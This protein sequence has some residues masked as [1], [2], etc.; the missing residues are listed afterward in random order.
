MEISTS[1]SRIVKR[2]RK[3][4]PPTK[5]VGVTAGC[6][7]MEDAGCTWAWPLE[8]LCLLVGQDG[9]SRPAWKVR[10]G[11]RVVAYGEAGGRSREVAKAE[12]LEPM[13]SRDD[14]LCERLQREWQGASGAQR[15]G[16]LLAMDEMEA[17]LAAPESFVSMVGELR[18]S[19]ATAALKDLGPSGSIGHEFYPNMFRPLVGDSVRVLWDDGIWYEAIM[20]GTAR[21]ERRSAC[22]TTYFSARPTTLRVRYAVDG[23]RDSLEWPEPEAFVMA[24]PVAER[25]PAR[26]RCSPAMPSEMPR[27][28]RPFLAKDRS[29]IFEL[30]SHKVR[31]LFSSR[32][33]Q[34]VRLPRQNSISREPRENAAATEEEDRV[35]Q[36]PKPVLQRSKNET[37][38]QAFEE[39]VLKVEDLE[40]QEE[41]DSEVKELTA[42]CTRCCEALR[43][44]ARPLGA[45]IEDFAANPRSDFVFRLPRGENSDDW[46]F[47]FLTDDPSPV[48]ALFELAHQLTY[49]FNHLLAHGYE[50]DSELCAAAYAHGEGVATLND[51]DDAWASQAR[52]AQFVLLSMADASP[53][54]VDLEALHHV[55]R[56][57]SRVWQEHECLLGPSDVLAAGAPC[58]ATLPRSNV[59]EPHKTWIGGAKAVAKAY[60]RRMQ[61]LAE[62]EDED[63]PCATTAKKQ[64]RPP[65]AAARAAMCGDR[66][67]L[68]MESVQPEIAKSL[69]GGLGT[70]FSRRVEVVRLVDQEQRLLDGEKGVVARL[71]IEKRAAIPYAGVAVTDDEIGQL[72]LRKPRAVARWLMY[73]YEFAPQI[74]VLP[75]LGCPTF[76]PAPFINCARGPNPNEALA[77][78]ATTALSASSED[79]RP[80]RAW[81]S[82]YIGLRIRRLVLNTATVPKGSSRYADGTVVA[83]LD[84]S[85][86]DF[87]DDSGSPASLW[88]VK[89]DASGPLGDEEEDLELHEVLASAKAP[90]LERASSSQS[91]DCPSATRPISS[92][93]ASRS[94]ESNGAA[95]ANCHFT[96]VRGDGGAVIGVYIVTSRRIAAGE[97]LL[98]T[99]GR[100]FWD[101]W[102]QRHARLVDLERCAERFVCEAN[103]LVDIASRLDAAKLIRRPHEAWRQLVGVPFEATRSVRGE[104]RR[105]A[106]VAGLV[107]EASS[108]TALAHTPQPGERVEGYWRGAAPSFPGTVRAASDR[109]CDIAYDDGCVETNVPLKRLARLSPPLHWRRLRKLPVGTWVRKFEPIIANATSLK[110]AKILR[111]EGVVV[112]A[113]DATIDVLGDDGA[114]NLTEN[115]ADWEPLF[116]VRFADDNEQ[117]VMGLD[118][119]RHLA[120]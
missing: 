75:Y 46:P 49:V 96:E 3:K 100:E 106:V 84:A 19:A 52:T 33:E 18:L 113:T 119:L 13:P 60:L 15:D 54:A 72:L 39:A 43:G 40:N 36:S 26:R 55:A 65:G 9:R 73:R 38:R 107:V 98:V 35:K 70:D 21:D 63:P 85:E 23:E 66:R 104:R 83:W 44:L 116:I 105:K 109:A 82:E 110:K 74:S 118:Q 95:K 32:S 61:S 79:A 102:I 87:V 111:R 7:Q 50:L 57:S 5:K 48:E 28:W 45:L 115:L 58:F 92:S 89:Y 97:S 81:G 78:S 101:G 114:L 77:W 64:Y 30:P 1:S 20:E 25:R 71:D 27:D 53:G 6:R 17:R 11:K 67:E 24:P 86:S 90:P 80:W 62:D 37:G 59:A 51:Y 8:G 112:A 91:A 94:P 34:S 16:L 4:T 93:K 29:G 41:A 108:T 42:Q 2:P 69:A 47:D 56:R 99:Y 120:P 88:R 68:A 22:D 10:G 31:Q 76:A 103:R 117:R 12:R 14:A